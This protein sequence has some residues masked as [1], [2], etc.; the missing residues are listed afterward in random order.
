MNNYPDNV[1]GN[2][3]QIAGVETYMLH[4]VKCTGTVYYGNI[5]DTDRC[6]F[7]GDVE[8]DFIGDVAYWD[9][10]ECTTQNEYEPW[11]EADCD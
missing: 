8:A 9:C 10:P 5:A 1:T 2:E 3:W 4:D 6:T 11:D 7:V